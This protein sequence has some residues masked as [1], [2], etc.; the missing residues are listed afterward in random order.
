MKNIT[1]RWPFNAVAV[2]CVG[3]LGAFGCAHDESPPPAAVDIEP[4]PA[5]AAEQTEATQGALVASESVKQK[6]QIPDTP[7]QAPQF[8]YD[9]ADLRSRGEDILRRVATCMQDGALKGQALTLIGHADPRGSERYNRALGMERAR[10]ARAYL[11]SQGVALSSL[12]VKSRGELDATGSDVASW[13]LDRWV[14]IE[15][16]SAL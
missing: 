2:V 9:Q 4:Q 7:Q 13:Q 3:S 1:G 11:E 15:E 14:D 8:D 16:T 10:A 5:A 6:C 12:S